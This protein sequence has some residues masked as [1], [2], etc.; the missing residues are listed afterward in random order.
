MSTE[1]RCCEFPGCTRDYYGRGL[2]NAHWQQKYKRHKELRPIG[3]PKYDP[4]VPCLHPGCPKPPVAPRGMCWT[5]Y[6]RLYKYGDSSVSER[7]ELYS[8]IEEILLSRYVEAAGPMKTPCWIWVGATDKGGYGSFTMKGKCL[9][10]HREAL[11][12]KENRQLS[13]NEYALHKCDVRSCINPEHLYVGDAREN[14]LDS[15]NRGRH[16]DGERGA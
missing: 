4:E 12:I 15:Y 13:S 2:C 3:A 6:Y 9:R 10:A 11:K 1:T 14:A 16:Y 5:H 7:R 8:S